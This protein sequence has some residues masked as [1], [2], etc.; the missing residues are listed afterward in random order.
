MG[1]YILTGGRTNN[2]FKLL[3]ISLKV[4]LSANTLNGRKKFQKWAYL[5]EQWPKNGTKFD[6]YCPP[7]W[8]GL[9]PKNH[10][11]LLSL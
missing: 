6:P 3:I 8:V 7:R 9:S 2:K 4:L 5:G 1:G 10:I 11:T